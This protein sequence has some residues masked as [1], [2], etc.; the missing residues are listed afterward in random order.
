MTAFASREGPLVSFDDASSAYFTAFEPQLGR[1]PW[2][3]LVCLRSRFFRPRLAMM[4][5]H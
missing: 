3:A 1:L 4:V 2:F 5:L